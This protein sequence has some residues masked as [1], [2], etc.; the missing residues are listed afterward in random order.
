MLEQGRNR[1]RI[2]PAP[3]A[4][5]ALKHL[6]ALAQKRYLIVASITRGRSGVWATMN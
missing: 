1:R 3:P 5:L 4:K 2:A 6:V